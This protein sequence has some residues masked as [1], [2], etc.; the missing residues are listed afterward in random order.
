MEVLDLSDLEHVITIY[1]DVMD[2]NHACLGNNKNFKKIY[3]KDEVMKAKYLV[4]N[5]WK[6]AVKYFEVKNKLYYF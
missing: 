5:N 1:D 4:D 2:K 6:F 3:V